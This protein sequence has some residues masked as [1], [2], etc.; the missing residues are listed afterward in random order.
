MDKEYKL[1]FFDTLSMATGF[2]IGS[3]IITLTG[4]GIGMTGRSV[5]LA[6][7]VCAVLFLISFRPIF[8]MSSVLPSMSAAYVYSKELLGKKVGGFYAYIYLFGRLTI[9]IFGISFAQY[10]ASLFPFAASPLVQKLVAVSILSIFY[11]IN[12]FGVKSAAK[13]QNIMFA[14]LLTGLVSYVIFGMGKI[15]PD[16]F[17]KASFFTGGV[18]G[19]Y[20][21]VSLLF[22]AVSGAYIITDFAP[23]IKNASKV[24]LKVIL[25][26][27]TGVCLLY[28]LIGVVAAGSADIATVAWKPLSITA[29]II[30]PNRIFYAIF[31]IGGAM[32][33]LVTTLNSSFVWYSSSLINACRDGW[34]PQ[35]WSKTNKYGAPY[36]LMSVFY[37]FGLIPTLAGIDLTV[38][39]KV[40]VGMTILSSLIPMAGIINLPKQYPKQ[41]S[42]SKYTRKYSPGR[43]KAVVLIT[44][45]IMSTQVVALFAGNP[46]MANVIIIA[47]AVIILIYLALK[48][49]K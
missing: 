37:L 12:L 33:A 21:T 34:L 23:Q 49:D 2:A 8:M 25:I 14:L 36:I 29:K 4:L 24:I 45:L 22:F 15:Q 47:Y 26:V 19:F 40:A 1:S 39:S 32:G 13:M 11:I 9:A 31:I 42:E 5:F 7:P 44:Y 17:D 10:F 38:I 28:M 30:F 41:W 46:P 3:G 6:F 35:S 16:F 43:L 27:T 20:T 48:K 18:S